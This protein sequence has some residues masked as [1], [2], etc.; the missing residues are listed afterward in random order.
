MPK[1]QPLFHLET[2]M[3]YFSRLQGPAL[4]NLGFAFR[5]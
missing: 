4:Q 3:T 5:N 2:I 1:S